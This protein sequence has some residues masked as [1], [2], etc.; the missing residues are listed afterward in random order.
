MLSVTDKNFSEVLGA[1]LAIVD[2]WHPE[3]DHCVEFKPTIEEVAREYNDSV[4]IVGAQL[5]QAQKAANRYDIDGLPALVFFKEG[6][7]VH[8]T[9][10]G[11]TKDELVA[12]IHQKLGA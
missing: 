12:L 2:F 1:P 5:D 11:M 6:R 3:C 7:E 10:G 8:R 4:L 9:E